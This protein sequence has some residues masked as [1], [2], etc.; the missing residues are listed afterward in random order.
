MSTVRAR[1]ESNS[2]RSQGKGNKFLRSIFT[3]DIVDNISREYKIEYEAIRQIINRRIPYNKIKTS[4]P[5]LYKFLIEYINSPALVLYTMAT[6][7]NNSFE[8]AY[9][10]TVESLYNHLFE[11]DVDFQDFEFDLNK[12]EKL[13]WKRDKEEVKCSNNV[14][15]KQ[16]LEFTQFRINQNKWHWIPTYPNKS[17]VV[18]DADKITDLFNKEYLDKNS[19]VPV[20]M[21]NSIKI[22]YEFQKNHAPE[23]HLKYMDKIVDYLKELKPLGRLDINKSDGKK[24]LDNILDNLKILKNGGELPRHLWEKSYRTKD[25]PQTRP[26]CFENY[27]KSL[28]SEIIFSSFYGGVDALKY[29]DLSLLDNRELYW[30]VHSNLPPKIIIEKFIKIYSAVYENKYKDLQFIHVPEIIDTQNPEKANILIYSPR[31]LLL[32][33]FEYRIDVPENLR[34]KLKEILTKEDAGKSNEEYIIYPILRKESQVLLAAEQKAGKSY[35]AMMLSYA[36]ATGKKLFADWK[37]RTKVK[38]LYVFDREIDAKELGKRKEVVEKIFPLGKKAKS[39]TFEPVFD[40]N[41]SS[42]SDQE[43]VEKMLGGAQLVSRPEGEPVRLLVLDHLT[44]LTKNINSASLWSEFAS[45]V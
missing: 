13:K 25:K 4:Y 30:I 35:M 40:F 5:W 27:S 17:Y 29:F 41:I 21:I 26:C 14:I 6:Q 31:D 34:D 36:A 18:C 20:F 11:E 33:S 7:K 37:T 23:C 16:G 43:R 32:K 1:E 2:S 9:V 22:A 28:L 44:K 39:V 19:E 10:N 15:D 45:M 42:L 38:V 8:V 24:L 3:S 12:R